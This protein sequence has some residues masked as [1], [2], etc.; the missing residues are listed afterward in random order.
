[1]KTD[2]RLLI[3]VATVGMVIF[4][5]CGKTDPQEDFQQNIISMQLPTVSEN[6]SVIIA[7]EPPD[8]QPDSIA[9]Y[10]LYYHTPDDSSFRMVKRNIPA[11]AKPHVTVFRHEVDSTDSI[12]HFAVRSVG[13][14]GFKSGFHFST[15]S[16]A[17][18]KQG[19]YHYWKK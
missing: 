11:T 8:E 9:C 10:E 2:K 6:D 5:H 18:P 3:L 4:F 19:W 17:A 16:T 15:D 1:M 13:K 12:F 7:W 14:T